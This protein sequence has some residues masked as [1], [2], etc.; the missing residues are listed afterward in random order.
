MDFTGFSPQ[1]PDALMNLVDALSSNTSAP[2]VVELS[3]NPLFHRGHSSLHD[4]VANFF[5][6]F[7]PENYKQERVEFSNKFTHLL[8]NQCPEPQSRRFRLVV[9]DSTPGPRPFA[10]TL[11]DRSYIYSPNPTPGNKPIAIGHK[12]S[13]LAALPEKSTGHAAPWLIPLSVRRVPSDQKGSDIGIAQLNDLLD[14]NGL[15]FGQ[16]LTVQV[17]DSEYS[18]K[19]FLGQLAQR[20]NLV[21]VV[22]IRSNRNLYRSTLPKDIE[23]TRGHPQWYANAFKFHAPDTWGAPDDIAMVNFKTKNG[24]ECYAELIGWHD[25]IMRGKHG[26]PMH[27]HPFTVIRISVTD[28]LGKLVFKRP[29][30]LMIFGKHRQE[31]SLIEAYKAYVQRYDIEHFFRFGKQRLLMTSSQTPVVEHEENWWTIVVLAYAQL[32]V[33][34]TLASNLPKPWEKYLPSQVAEERTISPTHVQRDFSRIIREIGT[35][36]SSPKLRGKSP[37]RPKG[38]KPVRRLKIP[39]IKKTKMVLDHGLTPI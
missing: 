6:A 15:R 16:E 27:L 9:L 23:K 25:L 35:P 31:I 24:R 22:R 32:W 33:A 10:A 29:L 20:K 28:S 18:S 38:F 3:L 34:A 2:S 36:A 21:N 14:D 1:R 11:E 37:G 26:V 7:S 4:A 39:V 17:G 13:I 12:Y 5:V 8:A 19:S 30:W